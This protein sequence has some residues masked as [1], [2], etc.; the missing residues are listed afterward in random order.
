VVLLGP[1]G[2]G[3]STLFLHLNGLFLPQKGKVRVLNQEI[4]IR[5]EK[6]VK[7]KVGLV[8]QDPD[9]QVFSATVKEDVAFGP[10]NMNLP[11]DQVE[12]RVKE[13][14]Q[15]VQMVK[16]GDKL[17]YHLSHGQKKRVAIAGVLAMQPEVI[18]LDEP[19]GYLDPKSKETLLNILNNLHQQGTTIV[20]A[21]HD[22]DLAAHWADRV[23][24]IKEGQ[25]LAQGDTALLTDE[26]LIEE[27]NL[28]FP[29]VAQIFKQLPEIKAGYLPGNVNEAVAVLKAVL[30]KHGDGPFA[31]LFRP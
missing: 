18:L 16:Y 17:P 13:A 5:T 14:L 22:V 7:S 1:N 24:I 12:K 8:F 27:A 25:T 31:S 23:I 19:T 10:F 28:C 29:T 21:T 20:I 30:R 4:T 26:D 15:A 9:D 11:E 2:A 3:K 6:W